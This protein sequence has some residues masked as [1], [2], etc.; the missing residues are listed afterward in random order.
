MAHETGVAYAEGTP[1]WIDVQLPDVEAGKRFYGALF[2]WTFEVAPGDGARELWALHHDT[3]VAA[4]APKPDGRL[5]TVWTLYFAT[6]DATTLSA[7][8]HAAGGRIVI[9]PTP[10]AD[11]GVTAL[12]TDPEGAVFRLW[13]P[14]THPG[15]GRRHEPGTF[16][17]AELYARD[18]RAA[19]SFYAHLFHE[20]LFGPD[21]R[22]D[23]GRAAL[24]EVFPA[25][26]PPHFLVHFQ[27][28]DCEAALGTVSRLGGRVQVPPFDTSY[29]HVA[30]VT[31]NQGASFA[32]LQPRDVA[33]TREEWEGE[34]A[35]S[36]SEGV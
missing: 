28:V 8:I 13:Q 20:A 36:G 22:P 14:G 34:G 12:A 29:G 23:F 11:L 31:D 17:W 24:T 3:P 7:R 25:E 15:F 5:P 9:P 16:A 19:N 1:C 21:A 33:E 35:G 6:P 2:G 27:T 4:L 32:L 26:M 18:T 30:V 10:L